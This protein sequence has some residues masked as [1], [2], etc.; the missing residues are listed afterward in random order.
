M[1]FTQVPYHLSYTIN[2]KWCVMDMFEQK[3]EE[4]KGQGAPL[5][6]TD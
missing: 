2:C 5:A 3:F 4:Q 1:P 6:G